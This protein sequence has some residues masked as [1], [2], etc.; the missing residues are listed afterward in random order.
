MARNDRPVLV[1]PTS[2]HGMEVGAADTA[3]DNLNVDIAVAEGL[4]LELYSRCY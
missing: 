1:S 3:G 4:G 2:S